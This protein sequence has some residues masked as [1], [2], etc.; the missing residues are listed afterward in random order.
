[1]I[2]SHIAQSA[3]AISEGP[4]TMPPGRPALR[5]GSSSVQAPSSRRD[6]AE[7][8][9][10]KEARAVDQ[11][12]IE[13]RLAP[14]SSCELDRHGRRF[15]AADAQRRDAALH[16]YLRSAPISVDEMRAPEAPIGWPSAQRAAVHVHLVVRQP[17]SFIAAIVT[18]AKA[19][20][21]S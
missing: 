10:A 5:C 2:A 3:A 17:C 6:D 7:L 8:V 14:R 15:A 13:R 19:S 12:C 4:L 11:C 18:T 9:G 16:P 21:I 1:L 20:L